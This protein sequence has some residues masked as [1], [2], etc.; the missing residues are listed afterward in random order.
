MDGVDIT[1]KSEIH[2]IGSRANVACDLGPQPLVGHGLHCLPL[3]F[4]GDGRARLYHV[5][6]KGV[7]L[8]G[9]LELLVRCKRDPWR[10]FSVAKRCV[11]QMDFTK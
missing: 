10:L 3:A 4:G 7:Q 5:N 11:Q 1:I 6:A 9:D 8:P 2:I